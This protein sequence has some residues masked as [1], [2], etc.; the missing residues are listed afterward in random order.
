MRLIYVQ[1]GGNQSPKGLTGKSLSVKEAT[2]TILF[3]FL[4]TMTYTQGEAKPPPL[5]WT[6][7]SSESWF[8]ETITDL[9]TVLTGENINVISA[10]ILG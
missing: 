7:V 9:Q 2:M 8:E 10:S 6:S 5:A 1:L 4:P 3:F